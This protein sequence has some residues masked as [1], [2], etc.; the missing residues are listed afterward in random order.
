MNRQSLLKSVRTKKHDPARIISLIVDSYARAYPS[1]TANAIAGALRARQF[2][3]A[4]L[5]AD[6]CVSQMYDTPAEQFG[7][8]QLAHFVRKVPFQDPELKPAESAFAK[9][10]RSEH[11]CRRSNQRF[12]A[13]R[14]CGREGYS[15]QRQKARQWIERVIGSSPNLEQI[16]S[17]CDL[18]PGASIGVT[19]RDTS[20]VRKYEEAQWTVT[21]TALPYAKSAFWA[22]AQLREYLCPVKGDIYCLDRA[23]FNSAFEG[24]CSI[25]G[26]NKI[27]MVPKT[28][29]VHRTIAIE[30]LL[31]T[32]LQKGTDEYLKSRL[33]RIGL[34]LQDQ[35]RNQFLA[36][37]GSEGGPNPFCTIDLTAASDS[38]SIEVAKDLLPPDW[39][40]FLN[41]IRS[42]SY[43]YEGS[44]PVR[45]QKF[46]SMGNGFC[47]P[48]ETLIFASLA[49]TVYTETGDDTFVVYGDDIIVRQSSALYLLELLKFYNFK[50][51]AD[52]TFLFGPFRESCGADYVSGVNVRPYTL[53]FLPVTDRHL[54]K[55]FNGLALNR[56]FM[57]LMEPIRARLY[58]L[59]SCYPHKPL[60]HTSSLD[61]AVG[62]SQDIFMSHDT[63][64][65]HPRFKKW[66][67]WKFV[68]V[69]VGREPAST[70][71]IQVYGLLRGGLARD[72]LPEVTL[73]RQTRTRLVREC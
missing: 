69:G 3:K 56:N 20:Y 66:S 4:V 19:S 27:T 12:R 29:K 57:D 40:H 14:S 63:A 48:L 49:A 35:T 39:F 17:L 62:V 34:D 2:A 36:L 55:I 1:D 52:K 10:L 32:F 54:I 33:K 28:A 22:H 73:R 47:F 53:D 51:N 25:V 44:A 18:G 67:I 13:E 24:R 30:P 59:I 7:A 37:L 72:Y 60:D 31:N 16:Y 50:A 23:E 70:S 58:S 45:Y 15:P 11:S 64:W 41:N 9:F 42:P 26:H 68:D 65:W 21:P 5:L 38:I 46:C 43:S 6:S 61:D 71:A 8:S